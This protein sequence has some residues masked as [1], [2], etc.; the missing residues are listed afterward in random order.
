[1]FEY[2][3]TKDCYFSTMHKNIKLNAPLPILGVAKTFFR[4][5]SK[6][7]TAYEDS[8][9]IVIESGIKESLSAYQKFF[10]FDTAKKIPSSWLYLPAQKAHIQ[11]MLEDSF[12]LPVPGL[13]HTSNSIKIESEISTDLPLEIEA[14][15]K[16]EER[17]NDSL[18]AIFNL[19]FKQNGSLKASCESVNYWINKSAPRKKE[20]RE[21]QTP[22][23]YDKQSKL[24]H[25]HENLSNE[26][27]KISGDYNP[28]HLHAVFGKLFGFK[29]K[30]LHGWCS[31]SK[32]IAFFESEFQSKINSFQ[33]KFIKPFI[34]P[35]NAICE[36]RITENNLVDFRLIEPQSQDVFLIGSAQ[37]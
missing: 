36:Y 13:V 30:V 12:P 34:L 16:I 2:S 22:E 17:K 7:D 4:K 19:N 10:E 18:A 1:M 31:T 27:A 32:I 25:F 24:W 21:E 8:Q 28:I 14:T 37:I 26:Y 20:A 9:I 23:V 33:V 15:V 5:P 3:T 35:K 6:S 29:G 11:M